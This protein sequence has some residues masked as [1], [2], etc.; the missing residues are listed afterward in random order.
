MCLERMS[1]VDSLV[2]AGVRSQ[3]GTEIGDSRCRV[4]DEG[5]TNLFKTKTVNGGLAGSLCVS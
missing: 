2:R 4:V 1:L 3:A 5:M